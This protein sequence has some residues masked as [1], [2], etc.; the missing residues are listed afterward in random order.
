MVGECCCCWKWN[1]QAEVVPSAAFI[2]HNPHTF[3]RDQ[4]VCE[5]RRND[6]DFRN[7]SFHNEQPIHLV[8][9]FIVIVGNE[10]IPAAGIAASASLSHG[11]FFCYFEHTNILYYS[12]TL[13]HRG[14]RQLI[15]RRFIIGISRTWAPKNF[16][17]GCCSRRTGIPAGGRYGLLFKV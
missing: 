7:I 17:S 14:P 2:I 4:I 5:V 3:S 9:L 13:L 11:I 10:N 16:N 12:I 15:Y 1:R 6:G 8:I